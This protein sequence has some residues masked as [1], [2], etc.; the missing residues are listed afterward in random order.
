MRVY[1]LTVGGAVGSGLVRWFMGRF[2]FRS[3]WARSGSICKFGVSCT[4][5]SRP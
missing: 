5:G 4:K 3:A 2:E 1:R